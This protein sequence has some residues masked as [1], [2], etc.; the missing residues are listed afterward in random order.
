MYPLGHLVVCFIV[1]FVVHRE[2]KQAIDL[3]AELAATHARRQ[4]DPCRVK[5]VEPLS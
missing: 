2:T 5:K 1:G 4:T 3:A